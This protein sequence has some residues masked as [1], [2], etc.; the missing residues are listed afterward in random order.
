[1]AKVDAA[2]LALEAEGV[3]LRG[4]FTPD[5]ATGATGAS[6]ATTTTAPGAT[7]TTLAAQVLGEQAENSTSLGSRLAVTGGS[8]LLVLL[9]LGAC[10]LGVWFVTGSRRRPTA[11]D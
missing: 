10:A 2:L 5:R 1:M 11:Q 7:S 3:A 9:G 4:H 6:G 8:L